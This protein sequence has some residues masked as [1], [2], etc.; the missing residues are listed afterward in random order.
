MEMT[1]YKQIMMSQNTTTVKNHEWSL[2]FSAQLHCRHNLEESH[3]NN[4]QLTHIVHY[5]ER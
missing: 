3:S 5:N 2:T 4:P 1:E